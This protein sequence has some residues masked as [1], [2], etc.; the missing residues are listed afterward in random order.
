M[1][2]FYECSDPGRCL[3]VSRGPSGASEAVVT[4]TA[5]CWMCVGAD[6]S[7]LSFITAAAFSSLCY[8]SLLSFVCVSLDF[9]LVLHVQACF[10]LLLSLRLLYIFCSILIYIVIINGIYFPSI[11]GIYFLSFS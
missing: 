5:L 6:V 2:W 11:N 8:A 4:M 10:F 7:I 1:P 9:C 3:F